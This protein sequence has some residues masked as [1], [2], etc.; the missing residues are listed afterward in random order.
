MIEFRCSWGKRVIDVPGHGV[1]K[2]SSKVRDYHVS[3]SLC[4]P[5]WAQVSP[6]TCDRYQ[7]E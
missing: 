5:G 1:V 6:E 3:I 4:P 2:P 7:A